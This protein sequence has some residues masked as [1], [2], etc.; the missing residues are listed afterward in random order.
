[1][2]EKKGEVFVTTDHATDVR[3]RRVV[4]PE[5]QGGAPVRGV[6]ARV[7]ILQ[8][9]GVTTLDKNKKQAPMNN[10]TFG[11]PKPKKTTTSGS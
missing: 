2:A 7:E 5:D 3:T 9:E 8:Q 11:Q 4:A 10:P 1:M 6:E